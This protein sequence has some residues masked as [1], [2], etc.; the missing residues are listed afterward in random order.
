MD[1]RKLGQEL[2]RALRG[3]RSQAAVSRRLGFRT[4]VVYT[5][6]CGRCSPSIGEFFRF[7]RAV[8]RVPEEAILEFYR[9]TPSWLTTDSRTDRELAREFLVDQR[10]Q[11]PLVQLARAT[12]FSRFAL[13]RWFSGEAEPRLH[14]FLQVLDACSRR[15]IDF[16][17]TL[18]DPATLPTAEESWRVQSLARQAAYQSPWSHAVLRTLET[19]AY[20]SL[21]KHVP[22]WIAERLGIALEDEQQCLE[23]L[24][25]SRQI[26]M[27]EERWVPLEQGALDLRASH[28]AA[29]A[30][31]AWWVQVAAERARSS[32]GMFAYNVCSI[33]H[34]D[35]DRI[36]ALQ[37]D[38]LKQV[39]AIVSESE[40]VERVALIAVQIFGLDRYPT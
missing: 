12:G 11:V 9:T 6:E 27:K 19:E 2:V 1:H 10:R 28:D 36:Q 34:R 3:K 8:K 24:S 20:T 38:F 22:G 16:V 40:P 29:K 18:A 15:V 7:M 5:W 17:A 25:Q 4:N 31:S 26:R 32:P 13:R 23:L 14:E 37:V 30:L 21:P 39:R 33:A 35:L